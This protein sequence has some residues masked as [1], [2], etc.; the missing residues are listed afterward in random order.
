[1]RRRRHDEAT[2]VGTA[3]PREAPEAVSAPMRVDAGNAAVARIAAG[4]AGPEMAALL[5]MREGVSNAALARLAAAAPRPAIARYRRFDPSEYSLQQANERRDP[6]RVQSAAIGVMERTTPGA[7]GLG[8]G[9]EVTT[10]GLPPLN[11]ADDGTLAI[12][13]MEAEPK[14]FYATATVVDSAND[15]LEGHASPIRLQSVGNTITLPGVHARRL[16]MVQPHLAVQNLPPPGDFMQLGMDICRDVAKEIIGGAISYV[17]LGSGAQEAFAPI[18]PSDREV[19]QGTHGLAQA[20]AED[21]SLPVNEASQAVGS[22]VPPDARTAKTPGKQYGKAIETGGLAGTTAR[23]GVN[24]EAWARVG[25]TYFT[26]SITNKDRSKRDW[27]TGG[28]K[29]EFVWGYHFGAVVAESE[30]GGDAVTLENYARKADLVEGEKLLLA[31]LEKEFKAELKPFADQL[32]AL[33]KEPSSTRIGAILVALEEAQK[34]VNARMAVTQ[35]RA[36]AAYTAMKNERLGSLQKMW[37]FHMVGSARG[38][39]FHEH[40]ATSGYFYN[41]MTMV[42]VN[43]DRVKQQAQVNCDPDGPDPVDSAVGLGTLNYYGQKI[44]ADRHSGFERQFRLVGHRTAKEDHGLSRARAQKVY[45]LLVALGIDQQALE[46]VDGGVLADGNGN[47]V[48]LVPL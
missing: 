21:P 6:F 9:Y 7:R 15:E 36:K 44:L 47:I 18:N 22:D 32:K 30:A 28:G 8:M 48:K 14:E 16:G 24:E 45:D 39:S 34:A 40:M 25:E 42:G 38:Q 46:V 20:M 35:G 17:R 12:N 3:G 1:M 29:Q 5:A 26:Q 23:L 11:V 4:P 43:R 10:P 41:P 37:F 27:S 2:D 13:A 31:R 19:I 33:K